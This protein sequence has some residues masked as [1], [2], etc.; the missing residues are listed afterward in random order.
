MFARR[1]VTAGRA[2]PST[3]AASGFL[4]GLLGTPAAAVMLA[5]AAV[6]QVGGFLAI[7]RLAQVV[8]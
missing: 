4:A 6:L 1:G 2:R 3:V 5:L 7:R 8:E